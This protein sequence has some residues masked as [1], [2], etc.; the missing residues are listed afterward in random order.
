MKYFTLK[1]SRCKLEHNGQSIS[2]KKG[3]EYE[4]A[5]FPPG[6]VNALKKAQYTRND[7]GFN[8]ETMP[9]VEF[10]NESRIKT[11]KTKSKGEV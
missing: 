1:A 9:A 2:F 11:N 8:P 10:Y 6:I 5:K 7:G 4:S 3:N